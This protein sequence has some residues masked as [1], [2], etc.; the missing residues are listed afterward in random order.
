V[1][2]F[3]KLNRQQLSKLMSEIQAVK[4]IVKVIILAVCRYKMWA[5]APVISIMILVED[6]IL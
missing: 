4:C 5:C 2:F 6:I 3:V 1:E